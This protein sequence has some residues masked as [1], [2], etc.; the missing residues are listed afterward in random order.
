MGNGQ[1]KG[2]RLTDVEILIQAA[3]CVL[4]TDGYRERERQ[5]KDRVERY[6]CNSTT[7]NRLHELHIRAGSAGQQQYAGRQTRIV[8]QHNTGTIGRYTLMDIL[9]EKSEC[10]WTCPVCNED[11]LSTK[12]N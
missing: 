10:L 4:G 8:N 6:K 12:L 2:K 9:G 3:P 1:T 5:E 7:M 11:D